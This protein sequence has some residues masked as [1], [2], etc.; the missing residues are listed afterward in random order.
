MI[1]ALATASVLVT[2]FVLPRMHDRYFFAADV[3]VIILAFWVPR[4]VPVALLVQI[5][6]LFSYWPFLFEDEI[7]S[8]PLLALFELVAVVALL[9]WI[10][11]EIRRTG[12]DGA[13]HLQ[14]SR[15]GARSQ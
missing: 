7:F 9:G 5:V 15:S 1:L 4:L 10:A 8:G 14:L 6:S 13:G 3:L 11:T 12:V 2:P